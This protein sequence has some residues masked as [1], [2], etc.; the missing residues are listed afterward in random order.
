ME[1]NVT[2]RDVGADG[3][4]AWQGTISCACGWDW[5]VTNH[6]SAESA[7][8]ALQAHWLQHSGAI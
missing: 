3:D 8:I 4:E 6:P 2:T 5:S 7:A 1:H